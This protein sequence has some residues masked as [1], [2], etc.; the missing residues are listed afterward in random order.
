MK[1]SLEM[2]N[3]WARSNISLWSLFNSVG[4]DRI[5]FF[6]PTETTSKPLPSTWHQP[7]IKEHFCLDWYKILSYLKT[8]CIKLTEHFKILQSRISCQ[9]TFSLLMARKQSSSVTE[10]RALFR[11][12]H[13]KLHSSCKLIKPPLWVLVAKQMSTICTPV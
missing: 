6:F 2:A 11:L 9:A 8:R 7:R 13:S 3:T 12:W 1:I 4:T 10:S 5:S